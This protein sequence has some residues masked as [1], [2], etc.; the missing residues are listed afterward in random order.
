MTAS[1][2][3]HDVVVQP[4]SPDEIAAHRTTVLR[5]DDHLLRRFGAAEILRLAPGESLVLQR[6]VADE[7]W[8]LVEGVAGFILK[9]ERPDSPTQGAIESLP[10]D[11]AQRLL[12][13]FGVR[14]EVRADQGAV[15][16]L[17]IMTHDLDED[18]ATSDS[19]RR[20]RDA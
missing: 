15:V 4:L 9:D 6:R 8:T 1:L 7:V 19:G 17:R 10:L 3:I 14:A 18:P 13:P 5:R 16:V 12:I 2:S 11:P 20:R